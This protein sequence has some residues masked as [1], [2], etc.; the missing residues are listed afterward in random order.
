LVAEV[1]HFRQSEDHRWPAKLRRWVLMCLFAVASA[2]AAGAGYGVLTRTDLEDESSLRRCAAFADSILERL[3]A[4]TP[5][6]Q[7][8]FDRLMK[9]SVPI[10]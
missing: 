7:R 3:D 9:G 6:E 5:T 10:R 1:R 4:M 2:M 8:Q